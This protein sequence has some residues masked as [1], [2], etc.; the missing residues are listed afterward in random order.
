MPIN[1]KN[2][3]PVVA[4]GGAA[5]WDGVGGVAP[6]LV[7]AVAVGIVELDEDVGVGKLVVGRGADEVPAT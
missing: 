6:T 4:T 2:R 3:T 1:T 7:V 5:N